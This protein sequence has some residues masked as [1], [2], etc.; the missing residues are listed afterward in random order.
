MAA[1]SWFSARDVA[2]AATSRP[3]V[4]ARVGRIEAEY[5]KPLTLNGVGRIKVLSDQNLPLAEVESRIWRLLARLVSWVLG[6]VR[7]K[8]K[9]IRLDLNSRSRWPDADGRWEYE[10]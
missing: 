8:L 5:K 4:D 2:H 1:F 7:D 3:I 9:Q 6:I 10:A